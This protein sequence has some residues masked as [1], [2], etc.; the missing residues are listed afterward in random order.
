MNKKQLK[1]LNLIID[2]IDSSKR[3][4]DQV[5]YFIKPDTQKDIKDFLLEIVYNQN[6]GGSSDL[7]Y[8]II[9]SAVDLLDE[10]TIETEE[11]YIDNDSASVYTYDRL[12]YLNINN[13]DEITEVL[14]EFETDIQNACAYWYDGEVKNVY[15]QLKD[16]IL[17]R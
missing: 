6:V 15:Y 9:A 3:D 13:Q 10:D 7:S 5:F 17:N 16:Y 4:N 2:S 11:D 14:K 8:E 12:Q 1:R